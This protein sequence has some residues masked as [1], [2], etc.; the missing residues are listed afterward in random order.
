MISPWRVVVVTGGLM[1]LLLLVMLFALTKGTV[2]I[3]LG[4]IIAVARGGGEGA[5]RSIVLDIRLPRIVLAGVVGGGLATAG[6]AF[7][8]LLKNPLAEPYILGVSSG[9]GVGVI[10]AMMAGSISAWLLPLASFTGA[11]VTIVLVYLIGRVGGRLHTTTMLLAGVMIAA[12]FGAIIMFLLST[13]SL[14][15]MG[16]ALFWLMG[17]LSAADSRKALIAILYCSAGFILLYANFRGLNLLTVGEETALHL[18]AGVEGLK[19]AIFVTAS[20]MTGLSVA[21]SGLIGFVGLVVPHSARLLF[22][23]DH[24][25]LLPASALLGGSF[26]V[27]SDTI[28][29]S[30]VAPAE[31]PVGVITASVGAPLFIYLLKRRTVQG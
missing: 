13:A 28:A 18:G 6:V 1:L 4:E 24:R 20:L 12:F 29:R 10:L 2:E 23:G 25:L 14:N 31:L 22:G 26:L 21:F 3:G 19:V 17:D 15:E 9:S 16:S 5:V 7:Q 8:A 11:L 27:I 30:V